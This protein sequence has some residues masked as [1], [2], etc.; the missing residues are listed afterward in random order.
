MK[1]APD[2]SSSVLLSRLPKPQAARRLLLAV[3]HHGA[4]RARPPPLPSPPRTHPRHPV[5]LLL[6]ASRQQQ[7]REARD[8]SAAG[9]GG[10]SSSA[11]RNGLQRL[12][13]CQSVCFERSAADESHKGSSG[14]M[15][16]GASEGQKTAQDHS[17]GTTGDSEDVA[18]RLL[19]RSGCWRVSQPLLLISNCK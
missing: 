17:E 12:T 16:W 18:V 15:S 10:V 7:L 1:N 8:S 19:P 14:L 5:A 6:P 13:F 4:G 3:F 11:L 9:G 2:C